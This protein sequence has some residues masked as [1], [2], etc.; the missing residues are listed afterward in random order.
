MKLTKPRTWQGLPSIKRASYEPR[1][2]NQLILHKWVDQHDG[3]REWLTNRATDLNGYV[4]MVGDMQKKRRRC[5]A[6]ISEKMKKHIDAL[7]GLLHGDDHCDGFIALHGWQAYGLPESQ[8]AKNRIELIT[9]GMTD[10]K[11]KLFLDSLDY[12]NTVVALIALDEKLTQAV[13]QFENLAVKP[14][15]LLEAHIHE[16]IVNRAQDLRLS[17]IQTEHLID[18]VFEAAGRSVP[19]PGTIKNYK[20]M[21]TEKG[22]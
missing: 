19:D 10:E 18:A 12:E 1:L 20:D 6:K 8:V 14:S 13:E 16:E 9:N 7:V 3:L 4:V 2:V 5:V 22:M 11:K 17:T 21:S 15:K